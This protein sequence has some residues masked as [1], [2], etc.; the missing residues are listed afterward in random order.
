ME[1][2]WRS[3]SLHQ[4]WDSQMIWKDFIYTQDQGQACAPLHMGRMHANIS[5]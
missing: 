2:A 1:L 3:L 5:E 4:P